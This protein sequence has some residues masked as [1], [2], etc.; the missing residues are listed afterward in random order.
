MVRLLCKNKV[1]NYLCGKLD[2]ES[3]DKY[4]YTYSNSMKM[5][6]RILIVLHTDPERQKSYKNLKKTKNGNQ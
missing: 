4:L 1:T 3:T 2:T 5:V 6:N